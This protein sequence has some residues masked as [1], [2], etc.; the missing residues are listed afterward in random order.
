MFQEA[1]KQHKKAITK[2]YKLL[3]NL[4]SSDPQSQWD[5]VC[6]KMHDRDSCAGI[7]GQFTLGRHPR[8]WAPLQD[9]LKLDKLTVF[10]ADAAKRQQLYTQQAPE[11]HCATAYLAN[12]SVK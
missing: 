3:R 2:T 5:C 7:N 8:M 1:Q 6:C 11:G 12:G 10:T 9:C 4:L